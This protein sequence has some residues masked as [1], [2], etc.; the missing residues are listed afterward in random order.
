M[1]ETPTAA[2]PIPADALGRV[3]EALSRAWKYLPDT[4]KERLAEFK[5]PATLKA[6]AVL[7][8]V[9]AGLHLVGV[10]QIADLIGLILAGVEGARVSW[11]GITAVRM[12]INAKNDA[13]LEAAAKQLAATMTDT[14]IDLL[15]V[16]LGNFIFRQ[17]RSALN[18]VRVTFTRNTLAEPPRVVE[19]PGSRPVAPKEPIERPGRV[20]ELGESSKPGSRPVE[21]SR[22]AEGGLATNGFGALGVATGAV[23]LRDFIPWLG[24][25][26]VVLGIFLLLIGAATA[27]TAARRVAHG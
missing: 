22:P 14:V 17:L 16:L 24:V 27:R 21:G 8:A 26:G 18:E 6:L 20:E 10:G 4:A 25:G 7:L 12:A 15:A 1:A 3:E 19:P 13:E 5:D 9:W 2:P 23:T 11:E